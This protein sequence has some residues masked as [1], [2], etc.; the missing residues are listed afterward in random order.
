MLN[1][2]LEKVAD[3]SQQEKGLEETS[4]RQSLPYT[5]GSQRHCQDK[6][7]PTRSSRIVVI[8][9]QRSH[10][11]EINR[12]VLKYLYMSILVSEHNRSKRVDPH[13]KL[14]T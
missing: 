3:R 11:S 8:V 6:P 14:N 4:L 10:C 9:L 12:D 13:S 2:A 7:S 1:R 5:A